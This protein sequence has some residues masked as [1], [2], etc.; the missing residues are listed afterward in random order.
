MKAAQADFEDVIKQR[1][2]ATLWD[3]MDAQFVA[4]L[5]IQP[6]I[7]ANGSEDGWLCP[8]T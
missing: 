7:I 5:H 2:L 4:A 3:T 8:R 1:N 6:W